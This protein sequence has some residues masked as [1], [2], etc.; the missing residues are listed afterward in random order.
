MPFY[1]LHNKD[2]EPKSPDDFR[3]IYY[4]NLS[5]NR[6]STISFDNEKGIKYCSHAITGK[7]IFDFDDSVIDIID[8]NLVVAA[9]YK[10]IANHKDFEVWIHID[11]IDL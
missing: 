7:M 4:N 10:K 2:I 9:R 11:H 3:Y 5:L 6:I 8:R 1:L